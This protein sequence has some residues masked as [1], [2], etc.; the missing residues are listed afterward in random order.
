M[1]TKIADVFSSLK[2]YWKVAPQ[3]RFI[4]FKEIASLAVGGIGVK[5]IV[6]CVSTMILS[7]GNSLIGNTIGKVPENSVQ[8]IVNE[9]PIYIIFI[10]AVVIGPIVEEI[11]FRKLAIDRLLPYGEKIAVF[12][13][14]FI[15]G[16]IHGNFYQFFYAFFLGM[17][18]SFIY[19]KT[20]KIIYSTILHCFINIF[21]K[22]IVVG[23]FCKLK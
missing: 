17:L 20:G 1:K 21:C 14:A 15:F 8:T 23:C 5:F 11:M 3:G 13:P 18:F 22:S 6:Y 16:L 7:I 19:V 2:N 12:L 9:V 4:P 10:F